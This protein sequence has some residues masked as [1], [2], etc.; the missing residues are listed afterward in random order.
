MA[1]LAVVLTSL[2]ARS[3]ADRVQA[4][5]HHS[6]RTAGA[7]FVQHASFTRVRQRSV[8]VQ[9]DDQ[10]QHQ[11]QTVVRSSAAVRTR[12]G[13]TPGG[14]CVV[15]A[16][17]TWVLDASM[18]VATLTI[19]GTL[20]WDVSKDGLEL[21]AGHV[22][23]DGGHL[24][25]GTRDLPMNRRAT[26]YIT[27]SS[28]SHWKFGQR[29]L[30]G[31]GS[32]KID[33]HGRRLSKTWTLLSQTAGAGA[34][35]LRL[36]DDPA[37]MGW[38]VG[39]RIGVATTTPHT[40]HGRSTAHTIVSLGTSSVT[41][42]EPL[43]A[44]HWGGRRLVAGRYFEMAAEVVNMERSVL[45]TG[46]HSDIEATGQG[47]HTIMTGT[48][49]MD[50]R[51]ARVEHCGQRPHMGRYC[52]HFHVM[53]R[54]E[55][56]VFQGNAVVESQH[57]GITVH[58]THRSTVDQNV[59]WDARAVGL[60]VED[61]NE[62]NNT[63][64]ANAVICTWWQKCSV[65]WVGGVSSQ[66]GGAF[67]IGMSN[68]M[69]GNHI[70]GYENAWWTPG[71]FRGN[72]QGRAAN[73]VCPIF[74]PFGE[75]RD[76]VFHDNA[77]FGMY[78]DN[79]FPRNIKRDDDGFLTDKASCNTFTAD[80]RDNGV[81]SEIH[82]Q[83]DWHNT[84][85][86]MYASGD[87]QFVN[88]TSVNNGHA[89]Y[90]KQSKNFADGRLWHMK[91]C[92]F[93]Q[94][95]H[96]F[97][98][99]QFLGPSGPFTFGVYNSVFLGSTRGGGGALQAG[100][101]CGKG[102]AG[103]PCN[104]Q[105]LLHQVDFSGLTP[106][107]KKIQLGVP[108]QVEDQGYVLPMFIAKDGS[109][110]G[111]RSIV[112]RHLNG[113]ASAPAN[114]RQ[115]GADWGDGLGCAQ[116]VRRLNV[117]GPDVGRLRLRGPGYEA[118]ANW[119]APTSG[120]NAGEMYYDHQ[121]GGYGTPVLVGESYTLSG[122]FAGDAVVEFADRQAALFMGAPEAIRLQVGSKSCEMQ[123]AD[124]RSFLTPLGY[125]HWFGW[126]VQVAPTHTAIRGSSLQCG[127]QQA[128]PVIVDEPGSGDE[129]FSRS[130][131]DLPDVKR[132][133]SD[134]GCKVL[135]G[136]MTN[137]P[138]ADYCEAMGLMCRGAWE[139]VSDDCRVK[140]TLSCGSIYPGTS[141]LICHCASAGQHVP[142]IPEPMPSPVPTPTPVAAP[143]P[144]PPQS[145]LGS[146]AHH[147][148]TNCYGDHG[149]MGIAGMDPA[150]RAMTVAACQA[151][152]EADAS[153]EAIVVPT[154]QEPGQCW[155][156]KDVDLSL[157]LS[158]PT[159]ET[160]K[161][162][163]S[164]PAVAP[165][166][167]PTATPT[168]EPT[169]APQPAPTRAP[170]PA[171]TEAP[172]A[173]PMPSPRPAPMRAPVQAPMPAP[174]PEASPWL[175]YPNKNCYGDHGA[176]GIAGFD[177]V[178]NA[179]SLTGCQAAC[180]ADALC[181]AVVMP[182]GQSFGQCWLRTD[183]EL[184]ECMPWNGYDVWL[185]NTA[186]HGAAS[187]APAPAGATAPAATPVQSSSPWVQHR[188]MNCYTN[189]GADVIPGWDPSPRTM[190]LSSCQAAC[191]ADKTCEAIVVRTGNGPSP[192]WLR[193]KVDLSACQ[194]PYAD[195][196]VWSRR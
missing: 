13:C 11:N 149:A 188:S 155:L 19:K 159:Y 60:Y 118:S 76:N 124:D 113:F 14:H 82:N 130:C 56:C 162:L 38:R 101:H 57:V 15:P 45:I 86:G 184:S 41:I 190:A 79:Q 49:Y 126:R 97:G 104:V 157:C 192:C 51:Y 3:L 83:F 46:D 129:D 27:K 179:V 158:G 29:F 167:A 144:V 34:T 67:W 59:V 8:L 91:D 172:R 92:V 20:S 54:C 187:F 153:C 105:Y 71:S 163:P 44:E 63:F 193:K 48:G 37:T 32:G 9:E 189:H 182:S 52:L 183:V 110:G 24:Q 117:W 108:S 53:R 139:E 164:S 55:R 138:C 31:I 186:A 5:R 1:F 132:T 40:R 103:G 135:A 111:H 33:I 70:V 42:A 166:V 178:P 160:W 154:N 17:E 58:G 39:D 7:A 88:Y 75:I 25:V 106:G 123:A 131:A 85:V 147:P 98:V 109:L 175:H 171:P 180:E 23:V 6:N 84:F 99:L 2:F 133:C 10:F 69:I 30:G 136:G 191:D 12:Q 150:P 95:P 78:L 143:S 73:R 16:G 194:R 107:S 89:F 170:M 140:E 65:D 62:M 145:G 169:P 114:C 177:P 66:G 68:N 90:W 174:T 151:A 36:K 18:S 127:N 146:W 156:R 148:S 134:D 141:D 93:A 121:H 43:R 80:G 173:A 94:D 181:E 168:V 195:Y 72:G 137:R 119:A 96:D 161:R 77:R 35:V 120:R 28:H 100:Q 21:R 185:R 116:L 87:L 128:A 22:L 81:V 115:L 196:D 64:S 102:G 4:K 122:G 125:I 74:H 152:C 176:R 112:S 26:I 50:M 61:G 142:R 47:L 165:T